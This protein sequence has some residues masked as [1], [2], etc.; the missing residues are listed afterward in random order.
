M[1]KVNLIIQRVYAALITSILILQVHFSVLLQNDDIMI[2]LLL[3]PLAF[4]V[5]FHHLL[6]TVIDLV[7]SGKNSSYLQ[8]A[9][10]AFPTAAA[11]VLLTHFE[12]DL[13]FGWLAI[14]PQALA[15]IVCYAIAGWFWW[16]TEQ[17]QKR[18]YVQEH[19]VFDL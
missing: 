11:Y 16:I 4:I 13:P 9:L 10:V 12:G 15:G 17:T 14:F 7:V 5:G 19:H 1:K 8:Y 2:V 3:Y 6:V 18:I